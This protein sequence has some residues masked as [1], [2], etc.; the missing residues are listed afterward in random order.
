MSKINIE[1][2]LKTKNSVHKFKGKG[3]KRNNQIIYNDKNIQT[4]ITLDNVIIIERN[5]DYNLKIKLKKYIKQKGLY[6][7]K[8]GTLNVETKTLKLIQ[9]NNELEITYKLKI[10]ESYIDTFTYNLKFTL[11]T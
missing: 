3:I 1:A 8:Y 7:T 9:K 10:N 2:V 6:I 4:K 11:D 5:S